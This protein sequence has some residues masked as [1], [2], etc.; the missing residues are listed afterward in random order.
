LGEAVKKPAE[1]APLAQLELQA[2]ALLVL[3]QQELELLRSALLV[4]HPIQ[5][6][7]TQTAKALSHQNSYL[8]VEADLPIEPSSKVS[9]STELLSHPTL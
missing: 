1:L 2:Q 6:T 7:S 9:I 3:A 5:P 8:G 4:L